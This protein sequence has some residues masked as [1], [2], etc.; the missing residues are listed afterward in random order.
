[1]IV[2]GDSTDWRLQADAQLAERACR[3]PSSSP[4]AR[5]PRLSCALATAAA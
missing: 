2:A 1:V 4:M 5:Q 3:K